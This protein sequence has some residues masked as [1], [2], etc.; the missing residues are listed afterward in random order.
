MAGCPRNIQLLLSFHVLNITK[1]VTWCVHQSTPK[2]H[3]ETKTS[4]FIEI[5]RIRQITDSHLQFLCTMWFLFMFE[6]DL[7]VTN[8]SKKKKWFFL[9]I[10]KIHVR[11]ARF[12]RLAFLRN[13]SRCR[14]DINFIEHRGKKRVRIENF[15]VHFSPQWFS[16]NLLDPKHNIPRRSSRLILQSF[17]VFQNFFKNWFISLT[18]PL[19]YHLPLSYG[20]IEIH[21]LHIRHSKTLF[22]REP[23]GSQV[24]SIVGSYPPC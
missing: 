3:Y 20:Q 12:L 15:W 14:T 9:R 8:S 23:H 16:S 13:L 7:R 18:F 2:M 17:L 1:R 21:I 11:N 10:W 22:Y 5:M 4:Y 24:A 6:G 19:Y